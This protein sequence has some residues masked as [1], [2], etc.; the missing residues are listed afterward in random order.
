MNLHEEAVSTAILVSDS[1]SVSVSGGSID[2]S[3]GVLPTHHLCRSGASRQCLGGDYSVLVK[4]AFSREAALDTI[5][6]SIQ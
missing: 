4:D 1:V 6:D 3:E 2:P 5:C